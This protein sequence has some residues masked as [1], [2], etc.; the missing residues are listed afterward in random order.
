MHFFQSKSTKCE[1]LCQKFWFFRNLLIVETSN[2]H[3]WIWHASSPKY[4]PL[5]HFKAFIPVKINKMWNF[6]LFASLPL[7]KKMKKYQFVQGK[8]V[9][10]GLKIYTYRFLAM[11]ITMHYV[12]T[13]SDKYFLRYDGFSWFLT[14]SLRH[15]VQK[16]GV[17]VE[18]DPKRTA[19]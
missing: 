13:L 2:L 15:R 4:M 19:A 12:R 18:S 17:R 7:T 14:G 5:K 3:H 11:P 6:W 16:H 9:Q 1:I 8:S 10:K